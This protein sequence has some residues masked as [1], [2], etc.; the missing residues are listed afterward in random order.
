MAWTHYGGGRMSDDLCPRCRHWAARFG[1][2]AYDADLLCML[3]ARG[4][5]TYT[6][7]QLAR[8]LAARR[9]L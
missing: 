3:A 7:E 4:I 5:D 2:T 1:V 8:R 6:I 9:R